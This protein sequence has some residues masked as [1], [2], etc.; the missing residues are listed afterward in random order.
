M[1]EEE[2]HKVEGLD[3]EVPEAAAT[4]VTAAAQKVALRDTLTITPT[5]IQSLMDALTSM[6]TTPIA[7]LLIT[8]VF[9]GSYLFI[10]YILRCLY[11]FI[12]FRLMP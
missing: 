10:H 9:N 3:K 12:N 8:E 2:G 6:S 5:Y 11:K 1:T 4:D 7:S